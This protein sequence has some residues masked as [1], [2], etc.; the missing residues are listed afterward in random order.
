MFIATAGLTVATISLLALID[1]IFY[2]ELLNFS[3]WGH[4]LG[5]MSIPT[6]VCIFIIGI[7]LIAIATCN[8]LWRRT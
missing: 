3:T 6:A 8:A 7:A 1:V 4:A 5:A 2:T